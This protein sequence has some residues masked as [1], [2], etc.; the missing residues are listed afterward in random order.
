MRPVDLLPVIFLAVEAEDFAVAFA[1]VSATVVG[2]ASA[3]TMPPRRGS[4]RC[5][6]DSGR[7][8]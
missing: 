5:R 6:V 8:A 4:D 3:P 1:T 7:M 2:E